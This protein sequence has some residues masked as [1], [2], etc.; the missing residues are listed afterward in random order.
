MSIPRDVSKIRSILNVMNVEYEG[1]V[2]NQLLEFTHRMF[3]FVVSMLLLKEDSD[4]F[5]KRENRP[6]VVVTEKSSDI[7]SQCRTIGRYCLRVNV[8]MVKTS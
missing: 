7:C 2:E 1:Q 3:F 6:F 8:Y 5:K 4:V